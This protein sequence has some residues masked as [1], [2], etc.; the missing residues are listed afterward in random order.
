[1]ILSKA[2][3]T[4]PS[5]KLFEFKGE[6]YFRK[7]ENEAL[8][9]VCDYKDDYVISAGGGTSCFYNNI[10]FMNK[11]GITVYCEWRWLHW[12]FPFNWIED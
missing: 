6:D 3:I 11:N 10:D 12:F 2:G 7:V 5:S 4:K 8:K 9:E 1:M